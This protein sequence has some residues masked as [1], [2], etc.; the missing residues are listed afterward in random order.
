MVLPDLRHDIVIPLVGA[1]RG[2]YIR[3]YVLMTDTKVIPLVTGRR[4]MNS[5]PTLTS[6][7]NLVHM[8][9]VNINQEPEENDLEA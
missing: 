3:G 4:K 5:P 8:E 6:L 1:E 2:Y 7:A 9:M